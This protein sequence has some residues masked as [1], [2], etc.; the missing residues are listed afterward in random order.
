MQEVEQKCTSKKLLRLQPV[1]RAP[2]R[3]WAGAP[4]GGGSELRAGGGGPEPLAVRTHQLGGQ[5]LE[6]LRR[7]AC[8]HVVRVRVRF[9][10]G[11]GFGLG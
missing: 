1:L 10:F 8:R 2:L 6:L 5:L 7:L 4:G 9:G 3:A 11:F